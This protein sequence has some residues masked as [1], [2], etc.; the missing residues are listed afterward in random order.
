MEFRFR[1]R[2]RGEALQLVS[3]LAETTLTP[4]AL[5]AFYAAA[6]DRKKA[7]SRVV[8]LVS[9]HQVSDDRHTNVQHSL[10]V[11]LSSS[12]HNQILLLAAVSVSAETGNS[13]SV[14]VSVLSQL[15]LR[16][17]GFGRPPISDVVHFVFHRHELVVTP[18]SPGM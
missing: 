2:F 18:R 13:I 4:A 14:L 15:G 12:L 1:F 10:L 6:G 3:F 5:F 9:R 7:D 11:L 8:C 17:F 16:C